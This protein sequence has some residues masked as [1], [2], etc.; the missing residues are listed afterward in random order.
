[1]NAGEHENRKRGFWKKWPWLVKIIVLIWMLLPL[2]LLYW[3][4]NW[5][6]SWQE[7]GSPQN[8]FNHVRTIMLVLAAWYGVPFLVWRTILAD[9]QTQISQESHYTELF[10][11]AVEQ[12]GAVREVPGKEPE[13]AL[14]IRIGAIYSLERLAKDSERDYGPIIETLAAYIREHCRDP[15]PFNDDDSSGEEFNRAWQ[16]WIESLSKNPPAD[17]SDVAAVLI[18]LSRREQNRHWTST[19]ENETQPDFTGVN[20]QGATLWNK[21]GGLARKGTNLRLADLS[22]ANLSNVVFWEANLNLS[23]ADLLGADLSNARLWR[24][25]LSGANFS[26]VGLLQAFRYEVRP[27]DSK[28]LKT[29]ML[30]EAFGDEKTSLPNDVIRPPHWGSRE[31]AI[32]QWQKFWGM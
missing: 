19:S 13:P 22:G 10:T 20:F 27:Q 11:K 26:K 31:E 25:N 23:N 14:E 4:P 21:S 12:L 2:I 1:M 8:L 5:I 24:A 17:R 7:E 15:K 9:K 18:V 32:K 16:E 30:K 28:G 3:N 6:S 29:E